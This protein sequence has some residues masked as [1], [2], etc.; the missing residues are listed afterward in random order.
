LLT[1]SFAAQE[2]GENIAEKPSRGRSLAAKERK[3]DISEKALC[4]LDWS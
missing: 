2:T 1:T 3:G 4:R